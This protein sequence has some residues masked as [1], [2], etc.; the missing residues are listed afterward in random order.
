M[1]TLDFADNFMW[2]AAGNTDPTD[3]GLVAGSAITAEDN[4]GLGQR[5]LKLASTAATL[6]KSFTSG[7][8]F[9]FLVR[10]RDEAAGVAGQTMFEV[11]N[12]SNSTQVVVIVDGTTGNVRV[13]TATGTTLGTTSGSGGYAVG[14]NIWYRIKGYVNNV[15]WCE[16]WKNTG[17]GW[18]RIA[19]AE[20]ADTQSQGT[21]ASTKVIFRGNQNVRVAAM[22]LW[23]GADIAQGAP[24]ANPFIIPYSPTGDSATN[25]GWAAS[26]GS[27][28][29]CVD[30][31]PYSTADYVYSNAAGSKVGFTTG[32]FLADKKIEGVEAFAVATYAQATPP[33]DL[34]PTY[35]AILRSGAT[36]YAGNTQPAVASDLN[37]SVYRNALNPNG[38]VAWTST[39]AGAA[40]PGV[41]LVAAGDDAVRAV[42]VYKV[43]VGGDAPALP[44][45]ASRAAY[46]RR[47]RAAA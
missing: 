24:A 38:N 11:R 1:P 16:V 19:F 22:A 17:S 28:W 33:F 34:T 8:R 44:G 12:S 35:R 26:A 10:F 31:R 20:N 9:D 15:G 21:A 3:R 39:T 14:T 23:S 46:H 42:G 27:K 5:V 45:N 4:A 25:T 40:E 2:I 47:R 32:P 30:E 6:E 13:A 18:T 36:D 29:A 7:D 43:V 37:V 41:E